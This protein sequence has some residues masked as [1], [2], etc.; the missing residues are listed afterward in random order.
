MPSVPRREPEAVELRGLP[1]ARVDTDAPD[2][3]FGGGQAAA[4]LSQAIGG[5]AKTAGDIYLDARKNAD[6]TAV[7]DFHSKLTQLETD[8]L[9]NREGGLT[10]KQRKSAIDAYGPTMEAYQKGAKALVDGLSNGNQKFAANNLLVKS[11]ASFNRSVESFIGG[12]TT[13]YDMEV[14]EANAL[15]QS[16]RAVQGRYDTSTDA[17][18]MSALQSSIVR[19]EQGLE[20]QLSKA[21]VTP[22][23]IEQR[24]RQHSSNTVEAVAKAYIADNNPEAADKLIQDYGHNLV[25]DDEARVT[26]MV[27]KAVTEKKV[28]DIA[29]TSAP[30]FYADGTPNLAQISATVADR[31][32]DAGLDDSDTLQ[33]QAQAYRLASIQHEQFRAA[34]KNNE[35]SLFVEA[36]DGFAKGQ[37]LPTLQRTL[38]TESRFPD[39]LKRAEMNKALAD[40]YRRS[41]SFA[42]G[43]HSRG[44]GAE[45]AIL[46]ESRSRAVGKYGN[47]EVL[48]SGD[49]YPR[50][51]V[52]IY[53]SE[54][55][56]RSIGKKPEEI[57][58]L[59]ADLLGDKAEPRSFGPIPLP[60]KRT[61]KYLLSLE[62]RREM[63]K[64]LGVE[65]YGN[66]E[67]EYGQDKV[68]AAISAIEGAKAP[69][70]QENIRK[71]IAYKAGK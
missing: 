38:V 65:V 25:G 40:L 24:K 44:G 2:A 37:T 34:Q 28:M 63:E 66:L 5:L 61:P 64:Q 58:K 49:E 33:A 13:K 20:I 19:G 39:P 12:E 1:S 18:G 48:I 51:A 42:D 52:D 8:L 35:R 36:L 67:R 62:G 22:E 69:V 6:E 17:D 27:K 31:S 57:R 47:S 45:G 4:G 60:A 10:H 26:S 43:Y 30:Q 50:K 71:L 54:L 56:W 46:Q 29:I 53:M 68:K 41:D 16:Q 3:A 11:Q 7:V 32:R 23:V 14:G 21:G 15:A 70:T 55:K 9:Y 59:A